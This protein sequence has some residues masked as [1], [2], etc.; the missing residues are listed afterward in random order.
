[1]GPLDSGNAARRLL[2]NVGY[3]TD[4]VS[5]LSIPSSKVVTNWITDKVAPDYWVPNS[6]ITVS[7]K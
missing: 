7:V 3:V 6:K 4:A 1:M 2:D 5:S